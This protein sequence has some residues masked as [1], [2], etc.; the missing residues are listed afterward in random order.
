MTDTIICTVCRV[1]YMYVG[2]GAFSSRVRSVSDQVTVVYV[3]CCRWFWSLWSLWSLWSVWSPSIHVYGLCC[4][5]FV[6]GIHSAASATDWI[7]LYEL[8]ARMWSRSKG[9]LMSRFCQSARFIII[10]IIFMVVI[11][12]LSQGLGICNVSVSFRNLSVL[13]RK[14]RPNV[15]ILDVCVLVLSWTKHP[16][17]CCWTYESRVLS[18]TKHPM[19][20]CRTYV[21]R[22]KCP[23]SWSCTYAS[24]S[25]LGQ[26][27]RPSS[28]SYLGQNPNVS[29][30]DLRVSD[31]TPNVLVSVP[32]CLGSCLGLVSISGLQDCRFYAAGRWVHECSV[33]HSVYS[34]SLLKLST[35]PLAAAAII[36]WWHQVAC[37]DWSNYEYNA[38]YVCL[39]A[40]WIELS[41]LCGVSMMNSVCSLIYVLWRSQKYLSKCYA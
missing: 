1:H 26:K 21:S 12:R 3:T 31:K 5:V 6:A 11:I 32:M 20:R 15:S 33:V 27:V 8:V 24:W 2:D 13:S 35:L 7:C 14:K 18:R 22:T 30:L 37:V 40:E 9:I 4:A 10:V 36:E 34:G 25:C 29:L 39:S 16:M 17:S 38:A 19:S 28:W 23:T 41:W